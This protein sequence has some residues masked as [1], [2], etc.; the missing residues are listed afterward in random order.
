MSAARPFQLSSNNS[1]TRH[2]ESAQWYVIHTRPR[3]EQRADENLRAWGIETLSP[4]ISVSGNHPKRN[5]RTVA[6]L[7]QRPRVPRPLFPGYIFAKFPYTRLSHKVRFTRG[8][9][10]VVSFGETPTP[11]DNELISIIRDRIEA[12]GLVR[13]VDELSPNDKVMIKS[14]PFAG[15]MGVFEKSLRDPERVVVLLS[16]INFQARI[17]IEEERLKK[18]D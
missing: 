16:T 9:L 13:L 8:I 4:L 2:D 6:P 7:R 1:S 11:V 15:F 14:G 5:S 17:V 3:Q 18:L 10:N 12:N